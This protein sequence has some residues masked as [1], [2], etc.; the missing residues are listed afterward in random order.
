MKQVVQ[1]IGLFALIL[2][3][4]TRSDAQDVIL[5][6]A[7]NDATNHWG[8][9]GPAFRASL[10]CPSAVA[11][12]AGGSV[13]I[14]DGG[15]FGYQNDACIRVITPDG[16]ISTIAGKIYVSDSE[17]N[18]SDSILAVNAKLR[19]VAGLCLDNEGNL[20]IADGF[21][22]VL[23]LNATTGYLTVVAGK[24]DTVGY[25]GDGGLAREA[26][27]KGPADVCMDGAGNICIADC[28]NHVIRKVNPATGIITTFAGIGAPGHIGDGGPAG[29]ARLNQPRGICYSAGRLFIADYGNNCI[30]KVEANVISTIAGSTAGFAGDG[31]PASAALLAQPARMAISA[32][33][34]LY[35]SDVAN[36][37]IRKIAGASASGTIST[38]A[39]NGIH[40]TSKDTIGN[41]GLATDASLVPYGLAFNNCQDL[42]VGGVMYSVRIITD[43]P[44]SIVCEMH[45]TSTRNI[46][47]TS[48]TDLSVAPNPSNGNF[49]VKL[50]AAATM[51]MDIAVFDVTGRKV[52]SFN[53]ET[54]KS[55]DISLNVAPGL[56][57]MQVAT[58]S[59][60]L[61]RKVTVN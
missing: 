26:L 25:F 15:P 21:S 11:T 56:Y 10:R 9:G 44:D 30:R 40:F 48:M 39:G 59:G 35:V 4:F 34:D 6:L 61:A 46:A 13:I 53:G 43:Q 20:I 33:G 57:L 54:N 1:S 8:D 47:A 32:A 51:P 29:L 19:G 60:V 14:G 16:I 52:A 3:G 23:K 7:G 38:F 50:A 58:T 42:I 37:R 22:Q 5:H 2:F 24:R 36:Q 27:L 28:N 18:W 12:T 17:N 45:I 41:K 49:S 31:G 55:T